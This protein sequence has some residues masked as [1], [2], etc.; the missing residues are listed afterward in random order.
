[1]QANLIDIGYT[2]PFRISKLLALPERF[3]LR[4]LISSLQILNVV[5]M[6]RE[7]S[8]EQEATAKARQITCEVRSGE[9]SFN[10]RVNFAI[11]NVFFTDSFDVTDNGGIKLRLKNE[12]KKENICEFNQAVEEKLRKLLEEA[13]LSNKVSTTRERRLSV[14]SESSGG[15][16]HVIPAQV[17]GMWKQLSC[18]EYYKVNVKHFKNPESFLAVHN[19]SDNKFLQKVLLEIENSEIFTPL[20]KIE[21]GAFCAVKNKEKILRTMIMEKID[22]EVEVLQ[23]DHGE[24]LKCKQSELLEMP[25]AMITKLPFQVV[26]CRMI[27]IRPKFNMK[28]WPPLQSKCVHQLIKCYKKP[29]K[30]FVAKQKKEDVLGQHHMNSYEVILIDPVKGKHLDNIAVSKK[31]ADLD[32]IEKPIKEG[33][34]FD[35]ISDDPHFTDNEEDLAVLAKLI[36]Q[37]TFGDDSDEDVVNEPEMQKTKAA[38]RSPQVEVPPVEASKLSFIFKQPKIEWSQN[39]VMI[40]LQVSAIDC[41]DYALKISDSS[42]EVAIEYRDRMEKTI[43]VFYGSVNA[44]VSSHEL[45]GLN[46]IVRLPKLIFYNEWPRLTANIERSQFIR[47]NSADICEVEKQVVRKP[48]PSPYQNIALPDSPSDSSD[49]ESLALSC[50]DF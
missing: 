35:N 32:P 34:E 27:G 5:P 6:D 17:T 48:N 24:I 21:I 46:I 31:I 47:Y 29:L 30:M 42:I 12:L 15:P 20:E 40:R 50:E 49:D 7:D 43:I 18:G 22:D 25:Q 41:T 13:N 8:W 38:D 36:E 44:K 26:N 45:C 19:M 10:C 33:P 28:T 37:M 9:C 2:G 39:D 3:K 23:L 11:Q 4:P 14:S 16:Q 1:M